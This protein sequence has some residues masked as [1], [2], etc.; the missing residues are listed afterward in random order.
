VKHLQAF[1]YLVAA[2]LAPV[3]AS[4]SE[5]AQATAALYQKLDQ[6]TAARAASDL[7]G[8]FDRV[9]PNW[10]RTAR[11]HLAQARPHK[12]LR[13]LRDHKPLYL[14]RGGDLAWSRA[15]RHAEALRDRLRV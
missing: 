3:G 13:R 7:L 6:R 10:S 5:H 12:L 14:R 1:L 2:T 8:Y 11:R 15:Q 9:D 4:A